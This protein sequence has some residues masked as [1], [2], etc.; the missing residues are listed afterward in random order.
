MRNLV[1]AW[2]LLTVLMSGCRQAS[3]PQER[4]PQST[5]T[6]KT[7]EQSEATSSSSQGNRFQMAIAPSGRVYR[8]DT[9]SGEVAVI[10][11][12]TTISD[13]RTKLVVVGSFY[14]T[15]AGSVLRYVGG[16]KFEPLPPLSEF[17]HGKN[18]SDDDIIKALNKGVH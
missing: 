17:D 15:E 4:S 14:V 6:S 10:E 3:E 12:A 13:E 9:T 2:L 16:A 1:M 5:V 18:V 7:V 11:K 8:L